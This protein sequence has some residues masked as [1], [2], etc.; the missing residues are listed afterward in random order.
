MCAI[1]VCRLEPISF[2]KFLSLRQKA[3]EFWDPKWISRVGWKWGQ[4]RTNIFAFWD[5][6]FRTLASWLI[7]ACCF[8]DG[9]I[10]HNMASCQMPSWITNSWNFP[11]TTLHLDHSCPCLPWL[12][13]IG[14]P[15]HCLFVHNF[16]ASAH[17]VPPQ[18][19]RHAVRCIDFT[20]GRLS[21]SL[22]KYV[23]IYVR[24]Y[25][26]IYS[27]RNWSQTSD[28]WTDAKTVVRRVREQRAS[29]KKMKARKKVE[30][31]QNIAIF[32]QCFVAPQG[33]KVTSLRR[34]VRSHC[35]AKHM[36]KSKW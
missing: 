11:C 17:I 30:K 35:G 15:E 18:L 14:C 20:V 31:S 21:F 6:K 28:V 16:V 24:M 19:P 34:R 4:S 9:T 7:L 29:R 22:H 13:Q 25:I 26:Y 2:E 3:L 33:R 5:Q 10:W 12:I 36:S 1:R 8:Q 32:S 27:R 23:K